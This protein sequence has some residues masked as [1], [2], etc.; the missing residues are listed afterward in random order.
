MCR[1]RFILDNEIDKADDKKVQGIINIK[2]IF[3]AWKTSSFW[4]RT[5]FL[6]VIENHTGDSKA[7]TDTGDTIR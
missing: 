1:F 2:E 7:N 3:G 4:K 6:S 5:P